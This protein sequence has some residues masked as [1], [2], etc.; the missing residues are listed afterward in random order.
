MRLRRVQLI[1]NLA[2]F[3]NDFHA[4]VEERRDLLRADD[5]CHPCSYL[6]EFMLQIVESLEEDHEGTTLYQFGRLCRLICLYL[7]CCVA[8]VLAGDR[9]LELALSRRVASPKI[10]WA[11]P[12]GAAPFE[13]SEAQG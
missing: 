4:A 6:T 9:V 13:L 7:F 2:H 5:A 1:N 3:G 12:L 11:L 8:S 10:H